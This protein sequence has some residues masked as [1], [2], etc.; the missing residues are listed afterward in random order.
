MRVYFKVTAWESVEIT[1]EDIFAKVVSALE[2]GEI[3]TAD[4]LVEMYSEKATYEGIGLETAGQMSLDENDYAPTIEAYNDK[5]NK[6]FDN[7]VKPRRL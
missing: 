2:N 6:V 1:D 7:G 3:E 5:H 4:E